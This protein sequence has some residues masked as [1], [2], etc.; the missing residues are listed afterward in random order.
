MLPNQSPDQYRKR[1]EEVKG[2]TG[3]YPVYADVEYRQ[4]LYFDERVGI[5]LKELLRSCSKLPFEIPQKP[6]EVTEFHI[7]SQLSLDQSKIDP[8]LLFGTIR[9]AHMKDNPE[10]LD[11][12]GVMISLSLFIDIPEKMDDLIRAIVDEPIFLN[13]V[14]GEQEVDFLPPLKTMTAV[15]NC[16]KY[17]EELPANI[18]PLVGKTDPPLFQ[19]AT[20]DIEYKLG[21]KT[22]GLETIDQYGLF[23]LSNYRVPKV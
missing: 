17:D 4:S 2:T 8:R 15:K 23:V 7:G 5:Q 3:F 12:G 19:T 6:G 10:T 14:S 18:K 11:K 1:A 13:D 22:D 21:E 16:V 20:F 9:I